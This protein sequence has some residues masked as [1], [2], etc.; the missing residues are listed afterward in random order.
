MFARLLRVVY[1]FVFM[2]A[3]GARATA[4][5]QILTPE[6]AWVKIKS[7]ALLLDCRS[8]SEC[9]TGVLPGA[10]TIPHNEVG[11]RIVEFGTDPTREVVVYCAVGGRASLAK[12][13]LHRSG[14][15][16]VFNAGGYS[17][18]E[19]YGADHGLIGS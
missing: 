2:G 4:S 8:P 13:V 14:F 7:G 19:A 18:L 5:D 12:E 16:N 17:A 6:Q 3:K 11:A 1:S 9:S 10:L 15:E